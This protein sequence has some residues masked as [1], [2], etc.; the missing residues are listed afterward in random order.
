MPATVWKGQI[1][2]GLVSFPVRLHA[3][4][5][6][7]SVRLHQLRRC[8]RARVQ[9]VLYCQGED[10]PVPR[11]EVVKGFQYEKHRYVAIEDGELE[12]MAPSS[13]R[14]MEVLDFVPAGEVDPLYFEASY[15]VVPETAGEKPYTLLYEALRRSGYAGLAQGTWQ[16]REHLVLLRPGRYGLL[17]HTLFYPDE[18][19]AQ[20]E[21]RTDIEWVPP[22]PLELD[23]AL[24]EA[25]AGP[26]QPGQY[27]NNYRENLRALLDAKIWGEELPLRP[28]APMPAPIPILQEL[29]ARL[30]RDRTLAAGVQGSGTP[31]PAAVSRSH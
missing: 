31:V 5:R 24:V 1:A 9:Q 29:K 28:A 3:A 20:E 22:R 17:L 23:R 4:A 2:F 19:R 26:F 14:V 6:R 10:R 21:F 8:D 27:K 15:F 30:A 16:N 11:A 13:S 25:L 7:Q 12:Q 18:I